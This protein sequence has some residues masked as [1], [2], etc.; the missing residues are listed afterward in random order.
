MEETREGIWAE[1][2]ALQRDAE[3]G[4]YVGYLG[5]YVGYFGGYVGYCGEKEPSGVARAW[6][7]WDE[8]TGVEVL[9]SDQRSW[10]KQ[11]LQARSLVPHS[12]TLLSGHGNPVASPPGRFPPLSSVCK[13]YPN[14][15]AKTKLDCKGK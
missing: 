5:G 7:V 8:A 6:G 4:G 14:A 11:T 10:A 15:K 1:G 9:G 12:L 3:M 2:K 13:V